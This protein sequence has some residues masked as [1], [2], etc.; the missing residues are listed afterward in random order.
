MMRFIFH[1]FFIHESIHYFGQK[2]K[3]KNTFL[4]GKII[5]KVVISKKITNKLVTVIDYIGDI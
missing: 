5:R 3:E 4:Y 2:E 1:F